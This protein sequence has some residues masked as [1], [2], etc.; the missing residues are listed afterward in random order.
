M[1]EPVKKLSPLIILL[2]V[3]ALTAAILGVILGLMMPG[4]Q[5]AGRA[6]IVE[7]A[8]QES[9]AN[10]LLLTARVELN[11]N[12][13]YQILEQHDEFDNFSNSTHKVVVRGKKLREPEVSCK[14]LVR[15]AA[16]FYFIQQ[17]KTRFTFSEANQK[18]WDAYVEEMKAVG[19]ISP[20][21]ADMEVSFTDCESA[22]KLY[23]SLQA[24]FASSKSNRYNFNF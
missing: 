23:D 2:T 15:R 11:T 6:K 18:A 17:I 13:A 9:F 5:E 4:F 20:G 19:V 21:Q 7:A 1:V 24:F 16:L 8:L 10:G 14:A 3:L 12:A 22:K